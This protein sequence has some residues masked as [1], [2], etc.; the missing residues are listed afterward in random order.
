[1][2]ITSMIKTASST[3]TTTS[4]AKPYHS[5]LDD[6]LVQHSAAAFSHSSPKPIQAGRAL[7]F[8]FSTP[9]SLSNQAVIDNTD[10][11]F[12]SLG[13]SLLLDAFYE[14]LLRN[15][16]KRAVRSETG[17]QVDEEDDQQ[18]PRLHFDVTK[19]AAVT[20]NPSS[21][22]FI[23][24]NPSQRCPTVTRKRIDQRDTDDADQCNPVAINKSI[25]ETSTTNK[26][27]ITCTTTNNSKT[28]QKMNNQVG[29]RK[30]PNSPHANIRHK[31]VRTEQS[32]LNFRYVYFLFI[33]A[34]IAALI[35][36]LVLSCDIAT[37]LRQEK[38]L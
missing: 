36:L 27:Y 20:T 33:L 16:A 4:K 26:E 5:N 25:T 18:W 9:S 1:M 19:L 37:T 29:N 17:E 13:E 28:T 22:A 31:I 11:N 3:K 38:L 34:Y 35:F 8:S 23:S 2:A 6:L 24:S 15:N 14:N 32:V 12:D 30:W 7:A 10:Y 21:S